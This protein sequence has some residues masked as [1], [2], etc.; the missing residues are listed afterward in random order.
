[1]TKKNITDLTLDDLLS[2]KDTLTLLKRN[3]MLKE[4]KQEIK[5]RGQLK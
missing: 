1:M 5:R 4:V 2:L 3:E